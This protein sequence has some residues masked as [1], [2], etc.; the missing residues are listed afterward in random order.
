[1]YLSAGSTASLGQ[2]FVTGDIETW[3]NQRNYIDI[4]LIVGETPTSICYGCGCLMGAMVTGFQ[5]RALLV[6]FHEAS[7][8]TRSYAYRSKPTRRTRGCADHEPH[9]QALP[10][11]LS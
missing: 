9:H 5:R 2:W 10:R 3:G 1:M 11:K 7:G 8:V 4:G 6:S